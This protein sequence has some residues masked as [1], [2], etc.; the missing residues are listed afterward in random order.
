M[1]FVAAMALN[2]PFIVVTFG[3]VLGD[4]HLTRRWL[5]LAFVPWGMW[6]L[7]LNWTTGA[8]GANFLSLDAGRFE[9]TPIVI[10]LL[11]G[12]FS[13]AAYAQP[14]LLEI[15]LPV[16]ALVYW[17]RRTVRGRRRIENDRAAL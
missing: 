1:V 13:R 6:G 10:K 12:G 17:W 16:G 9:V 2:L 14:W 8:L 15:G 4:R 11:G 7:T 5:W 3:A